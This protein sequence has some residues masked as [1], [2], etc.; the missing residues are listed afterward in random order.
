MS[1]V[2]AAHQP[3]FLPDLHVLDKMRGADELGTEPGIF[4]IRDDAQYV[5]GHKSYH[6]R[7]MIR[8]NTGPGYMW[9]NI[10]IVKDASRPLRDRLLRDTMINESSRVNNVPWR[11]YHLRMI[12]DNYK[13]TPFFDRFFP[14]LQEIYRE[15]TGSLTAFNMRIIEWLRTCFCITTE[16]ISL[17][18]LLEGTRTEDKSET[19]ANAAVAVGADLYFSGDGSKSYLDLSA[20]EQKGITVRF[21]N[22]KHPAYPQRFLG[23]RPKMA[24]IDALLNLGRLPCS[25]EV[26]G[27]F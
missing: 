17:Y 9:L 18:D 13:K 20:F 7:C 15:P 14:E 4:I 21:Q 22:Y 26:L 12:H 1:K 10:P 23:F 19:L 16:M 24:A 5:K 27:E 8:T 2:M 11:D 3:N 25:G 6:D